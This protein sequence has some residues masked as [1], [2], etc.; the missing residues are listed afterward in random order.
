MMEGEAAAA[1]APV[2]Q[3]GFVELFSETFRF[4]G[5]NFV[6][7]ASIIFPV[8][9]V[10]NIVLPFLQDYI[11][12]LAGILGLATGNEYLDDIINDV[13]G[14]LLI[15]IVA[16]IMGGIAEIALIKAVTDQLSGTPVSLADAFSTGV[17]L[18]PFYA[19]T[20]ILFLI[21]EGIGW[22]LLLIPGIIIMVYWG[23]WA[24]AVVLRDQHTFGAFSYSYRLVSGNFLRIL[25]YWIALFILIDVVFGVI[26]DL[27]SGFIVQG[28]EGEMVYN[29]TSALADALWRTVETIYAIFLIIL[30]LDLEKTR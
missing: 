18:L 14:G 29:A 13:L 23:F 30:F 20:G 26:W 16:L 2:Q 19:I 1:P 4:F 12:D 3:K 21:I 17:S 6:M 8:F 25:L 24:M 9:F 5:S 15:G 11:P 7:I 27:I 28:A 10:V 22:I